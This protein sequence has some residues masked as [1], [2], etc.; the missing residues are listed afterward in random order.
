MLEN[1]KSVTKIKLFFDFFLKLFY[2]LNYMFEFYTKINYIKGI[3]LFD[4][5]LCLKIF[6][7]F[8]IKSKDGIISETKDFIK[9]KICNLK[10]HVP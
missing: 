1:I 2:K 5:K 3:F 8:Y 6:K 7:S 9:I 4:N 10:K